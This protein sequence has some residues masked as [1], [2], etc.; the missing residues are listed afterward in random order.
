MKIPSTL[1][2]F[3]DKSGLIV[4]TGTEELNFYIAKDGT[5]NNVFHFVLEKIKFSDREDTGRRGK[6][7]FETDNKIEKIKKEM[8]QTFLKNFK[9]EI[10][11][12]LTAQNVDLVYI[13]APDSV[14]KELGKELPTI[15][16]KKLVKSYV[17]NFC[18]ETPLNIL[19][20]IK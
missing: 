10:K 17:G 19:K 4:V 2:Q 11:K 7:A 15:L 16:K 13:F 18:R 9:E 5:I 3:K 1:L 12:M 8:R 6:T 14:L 20:K